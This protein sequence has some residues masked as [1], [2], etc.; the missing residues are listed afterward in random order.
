MDRESLPA[1][2]SIDLS[3]NYI[4]TLVGLHDL[5][6]LKTLCLSG[7]Q[8][9][10]MGI[11]P[12]EDLAYPIFAQLKSL[13]LDNND[14]ASLVDLELHRI[15]HLHYLFLQDNNLRN[16]QGKFIFHYCYFCYL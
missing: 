4:T 14:I 3:Y 5:R 7:N 1:L 15:R 9:S 8:V 16:L 6:V 2:E 13:Y 11:L 10:C 12:S